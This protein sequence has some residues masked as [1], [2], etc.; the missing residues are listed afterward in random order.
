MDAGVILYVCWCVIEPQS[1]YTRNFAL[2]LVNCLSQILDVIFFFRSVCHH[3][4]KVDHLLVKKPFLIGLPSC[5]CIYGSLYSSPNLT[6]YVQ[7]L[8]LKVF[9]GL[10]PKYIAELLHVFEIGNSRLMGKKTKTE[11]KTVFANP[12]LSGFLLVTSIYGSRSVSVLVSLYGMNSLVT[13][14]TKALSVLSSLL[15]KLVFLPMNLKW[16]LLVSDIVISTC[17]N[18]V[19]VCRATG[20]QIILPPP[21]L[22]PNIICVRINSNLII[23]A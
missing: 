5:L 18:V 8:A 10:D 14:E 9:H 3:L 4:S 11:Q 23:S 7:S 19:I 22:W 12:A 13:S 1:H 2:L 15:W 16:C 17:V 21:P 6:R 20:G